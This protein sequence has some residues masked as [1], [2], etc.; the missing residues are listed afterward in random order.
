MGH[1]E[2]EA[3][4]TA[5]SS[6]WS[7]AWRKIVFRSKNIYLRTYYTSIIRLKTCRPTKG[8]E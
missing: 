5:S 1:E 3:G 7:E 8:E 4:S 6:P 2:A